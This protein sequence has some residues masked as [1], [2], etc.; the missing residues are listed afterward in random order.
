MRSLLTAGE[1]YYWSKTRKQ[2]D[3]ATHRRAVSEKAL[4]DILRRHLINVHNLQETEEKL[5]AMEGFQRFLKS[6]STNDERAAFLEHLRLYI[7][8][9]RTDTP[10]EVSTT[11]RYARDLIESKVTARDMISRGHYVKGLSG[12]MVMLSEQEAEGLVNANKAVSLVQLNQKQRWFFLGPARFVN[13]DCHPNAKLVFDADRRSISVKVIEDIKPGQEI[14]VG[15]G[16]N[17]FGPGNIE[18]LCVSCEESIRGGWSIV[19]SGSES[20]EE[21][22]PAPHSTPRGQ[23]RP[24]Q[25]IDDS[26]FATDN[27]EG[28]S[29]KRQKVSAESSPDTLENYVAQSTEQDDIVVP[30]SRPSSVEP[31]RVR[32]SADC[33]GEIRALILE[34]LRS[35]A[36]TDRILDRLNGLNQ[37]IVVGETSRAETPQSRD[38]LWDNQQDT[39]SPA[40]TLPSS[41]SSIS[42]NEHLLQHV[43]PLDQD[44]HQQ[45]DMVRQHI[46]SAMAV[47][48]SS[49]AVS[50]TLGLHTSLKPSG[51]EEVACQDDS[52]D[53]N[54][55]TLMPPYDRPDRRQDSS[56]E[57]VPEL[58]PLDLIDGNVDDPKPIATSLLPEPIRLNDEVPPHRAL[59]DNLRP[60]CTGAGPKRRYPG[61]YKSPKLLL[62]GQGSR[63]V[64]CL[65]CGELWIHGDGTETRRE[66]PRCERHINLYGLRWPKTDPD[67][68]PGVADDQS[69]YVPYQGK[70]KRRKNPALNEEASRSATIAWKKGKHLWKN[71]TTEPNEPNKRIMNHGLID[72]YMDRDEEQR[73]RKRPKGLLILAVN[74]EV[75]DSV[76]EGRESYQRQPK[77]KRVEEAYLKHPFS[78]LGEAIKR[79]SKLGRS[80]RH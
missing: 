47:L 56:P 37:P 77:R 16:K 32:Q 5:L 35:E 6:L 20:S 48:N 12:T 38:S 34:E 2:K 22:I 13:H 58:S 66:C 45:R 75:G 23:K 41:Q 70:Y 24:S 19:G 40:T 7:D 30:D 27:E 14:T 78:D 26:G 49:S 25:D 57:L 4:T 29:R 1:V 59:Q 44:M 18:C 54:L 15:Y 63:E 53:L 28:P 73:E 64:Q 46:F 80:E 42:A 21:R 79:Q 55:S 36:F 65:T 17:F 39:S 50:T 60:G 43:K 9:W 51:H 8:L 61:D 71:W 72:R 52:H 62:A 33:H 68:E 67:L 3:T 69:V 31:A 74:E 11:N 10:F 76:L